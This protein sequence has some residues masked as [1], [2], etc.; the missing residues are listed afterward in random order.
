MHTQNTLPNNTQIEQYIVHTR[1][2]SGYQ[3]S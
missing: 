1:I 2:D 3:Y